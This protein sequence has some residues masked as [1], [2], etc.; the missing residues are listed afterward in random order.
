MTEAPRFRK[1]V[2]AITASVLLSTAT[3][4]ALADSGPTKDQE[5]A[6]KRG[7]DQYTRGDYGGAILVWEKLV[8]TLGPARGIKVLYNLGL[9]H[10]S[11]GDVTR[12]VEYYGTFLAEV[13]KLTDATDLAHRRDDARARMD[14]LVATHA[15]VSVLAPAS[16]NSVLTR[17]GIGTPR[18]AGYKAFLAPGHHEVEFFVGTDHV[19]RVPLDVEAGKSYTAQVAPVPKPPPPPIES[20]RDPVPAPVYMPPAPPPAPA[21]VSDGSARR[22]WLLFGGGATA[23]TLVVPTVLY[24]VADGQKDTAVTQGPGHTKYEADKSSYDTTRTLYY[25]S[26]SLPVVAIG[27]TLLGAFVLSDGP[28][29]RQALQSPQGLSF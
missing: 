26:F 5:A 16:D 22:N 14:K 7:L 19:Q 20:L 15:E 29:K 21:P 27:V 17:I 24:L 12:A 25:T 28:G 18:A 11:I 23:L 4:P 9:A 8:E 10:E 6:F 1:V 2:A 3:A 13:A